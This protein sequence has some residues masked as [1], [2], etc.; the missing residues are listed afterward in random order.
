M[1]TR[2]ITVSQLNNYI[3]AVFDAEE[4]LHGIEVV[5]EVEGL[6]V[7]GS[8]VYFSLKDS[9]AVIQCVS[10]V[11]AKFKDIKNGD[12]VTIRGRVSFW[13]KAGKINFSVSHIEV[14]GLGEMF[15]KL[16]E[17]KERLEKEGLF[18]AGK[19]IP[20][21]QNPRRIGIVTSGQ[22]AVIHDIIKVAHRRNPF[23]DLVLYPVQVHS[24]GFYAHGVLYFQ[25]LV[26]L[27]PFL[28]R[29]C[30]QQIPTLIEPAT[31]GISCIFL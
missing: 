21:P 19:K 17:L 26:K 15:Q 5:G 8:A 23:I 27:L 9:D 11:P 28:F 16:I 13:H 29:V 4:M 25:V 31:P 24:I 30:D 10:Y 18:D 6:S 22:G 20:L 3:K 7:R 12:K 2:L 1:K 14:F